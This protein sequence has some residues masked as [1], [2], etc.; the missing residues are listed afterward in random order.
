MLLLCAE[1]VGPNVII[2]TLIMGMQNSRIPTQQVSVLSL[3]Q[4]LVGAFGASAIDLKSLLSYVQGEKGLLSTNPEVKKQSIEL[5]C[6]LHRQLGDV[7]RALIQQCGL[8]DL[9]LKTV[10]TSLDEAPFDPHLADRYAPARP[11]GSQSLAGSSPRGAASQSKPGS[12]GATISLSDLVEAADL[13]S[14]MGPLLRAMQDVDGK[15]SWKRRQ[16]AVLDLT[17]LVKQKLRVVNNKAVS[18]AMSVL[19]DRLSESNLNFRARVLQCIGQ[20]AESLGAE[21]AKYNAMLLP[22]LVKSTIDSNKNV[23]ESLYSALTRWV[24]HDSL[25]SLGP[26]LPHLLPAFR[27]PKARPALLRWLLPLLAP[28]DSRAASLLLPD[29]LDCLLDR[30]PEVRSLALHACKAIAP[31]CTRSLVEDRIRAHKPADLRTLQTVWEPL[32]ADCAAPADTPKPAGIAASSPAQTEEKGKLTEARR[33]ALANRP[34]A[35]VLS[36]RPAA[37]IASTMKRQA[38]SSIPKPLPPLK[39]RGRQAS[40]LPQTVETVETGETT[41]RREP[42]RMEIEPSPAGE[43]MSAGVSLGNGRAGSVGDGVQLPTPSVRCAGWATGLLTRSGTLLT[44]A[45]LENFRGPKRAFRS[46]T[47]V[48]ARWIGRFGDLLGVLQSSEHVMRLHEQFNHQYCKAVEACAEICGLCDRAAVTIEPAGASEPPRTAVSELEEHLDCVLCVVSDVLEAILSGT[49]ASM[50]LE[51]V[52]NLVN[53][54]TLLLKCATRSN[55]TSQTVCKLLR[56]FIAG[57]SQPVSLDE[58]PSIRS[59]FQQ[60]LLQCCVWPGFDF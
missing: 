9:L 59:V 21:V 11:T 19:K 38:V 39:Q 34:G 23:I 33:Q 36:K 10:M 14:E 15:D 8:N 44:R 13:S 43:P 53:A 56:T 30:T 26:A 31:K 5:V 17:A 4:Q 16:Q 57:L 41:E 12:A 40:P 45:E 47:S 20:F 49:D 58:T 24:L 51:I 7:V 46:E 60:L 2:S 3:F 29:L 50:E 54:T 27:N 6:A 42:E 22:E 48:V 32:W 37:S 52:Q 25:N 1:G 28:L 35:R 18:D 55:L